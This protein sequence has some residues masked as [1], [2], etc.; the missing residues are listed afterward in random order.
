V[1]QGQMLHPRTSKGWSICL[2]TPTTAAGSQPWV[3]L[4]LPTELADGRRLE[5]VSLS[6]L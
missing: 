5:G 6:D 4:P 1:G 2:K 3:V